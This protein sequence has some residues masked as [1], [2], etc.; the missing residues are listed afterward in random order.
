M[1]H[2]SLPYCSLD[3]YS[4][5]YIYFYNYILPPVFH[6][7]PLNIFLYFLIFAGVIAAA[8]RFRRVIGC[9]SAG[10]VLIILFQLHWQQG[11]WMKNRRMRHG[12][13]KDAWAG[14]QGPRERRFSDFVLSHV[15]SGS[16]CYYIE[17]G[18]SRYMRYRLYPGILVTDN[19]K[20]P[21]DCVV[22][23]QMKEP[24]KYVPPGFDRVLWFDRQSLLAIKRKI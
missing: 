22:V 16:S 15:P 2:H 10:L 13:S 8:G 3:H 18:N 6:K 9:V 17:A 19:Q 20:G 7:I 5:G 11:Y 12:L 23:F 14:A 1:F 21:W 24:L 4:W